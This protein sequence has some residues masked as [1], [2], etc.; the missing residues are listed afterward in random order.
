M[1]KGVYATEIDKNRSTRPFN[2]DNTPGKIDSHITFTNESRNELNEFL[3]NGDRYEEY[4]GDRF[5]KYAL[6]MQKK[7]KRLSEK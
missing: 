6:A 2:I 5:Q 1:L 3:K 7:I 4:I